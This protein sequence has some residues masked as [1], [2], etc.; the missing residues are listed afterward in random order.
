MDAPVASVG[1]ENF[2]DL[3]DHI[4]IE[5]LPKNTS[6]LIQPMDQGI[7]F[8]FKAYYQRITSAQPIH[9]T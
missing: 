7:I 3:S 4:R 6:A 9:E 1:P 5:Y 2:N 8:M